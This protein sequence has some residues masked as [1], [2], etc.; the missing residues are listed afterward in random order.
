MKKNEV[1]EFLKKHETVIMFA[2]TGV[3]VVVA[4]RLGVRHV[5]KTTKLM[6]NN[7]II[8]E[9]LNNAKTVY[10]SDTVVV[11]GAIRPNG[12]QPD[13]LRETFARLV[14]EKGASY[15]KLTHLIAIGPQTK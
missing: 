5:Y 15:D 12:C 4:Y 13:E 11:C 1:K 7:E 9:V 10:G 14:D 3:A 6:T 8:S 2:F